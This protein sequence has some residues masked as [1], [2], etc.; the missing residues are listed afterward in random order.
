MLVPARPQPR[1][2]SPSSLSFSSH[3]FHEWHCGALH[4]SP[5]ALCH[6]SLIPAAVFALA[7]STSVTLFSASE[8]SSL[9]SFT[10]RA[11]RVIVVAGTWASSFRRTREATVSHRDYLSASGR[12][13]PLLL[14]VRSFA[15][16]LS[17]HSRLWAW[18]HK[19]RMHCVRTDCYTT[20]VC[21][22]I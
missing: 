4:T 17:R 16:S 11:G 14:V 22:A 3:D 15:A 7:A 1:S 2:R 19:R 6:E 10:E 13:P 8:P 5:L 9:R 21:S 20:R 18:A 12:C